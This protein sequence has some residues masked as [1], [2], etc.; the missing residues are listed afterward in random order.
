MRSIQEI[1]ISFP[2]SKSYPN[3][4]IPNISSDRKYSILWPQRCLICR[5]KKAI[6][7]NNINQKHDT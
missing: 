1:L 2:Q 7:Q 4:N 6:Y 5:N 3:I